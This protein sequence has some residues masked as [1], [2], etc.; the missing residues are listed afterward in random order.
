MS[1]VGTAGAKERRRLH[2]AV[3]DQLREL[4]MQLSMLNARVGSRLQFKTTDLD[5]LDLIVRDGGMTP[6]ALAR[7]SG[8]HPATL[9][10]VLDRLERDG[11]VVRERQA[12]DRRAVLVRPQTERMRDIFLL[13][14][15]M[16]SA[17]DD[18]CGDYSNDELETIADFLRRVT[19]AGERAT[20]DLA[21]D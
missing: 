15:G 9:T 4:R 12:T 7:R 6:T 2:T 19:E 14:S 21:R 20:D 3:R 8:L 17:I 16:N 18:I 1:P 13:Y 10:G 11:W 5:V